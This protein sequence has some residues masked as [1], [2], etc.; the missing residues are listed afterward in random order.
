[1]IPTETVTFLNDMCLFAPAALID[2]RITWET[3]D[4]VSA[5]AT[6][7]TNNIR[8]SAILDFDEEGK[9]V[10][11]V[12][13]DR[14]SVDEMKAYPFSTPAG[15]YEN[16]NG[17]NLPM[18]GEGVWHYPDGEFVYGKFKVKSIEY[19]LTEFK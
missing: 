2:D 16:T 8:I 5:R 13:N 3:L 1:M 18:Y 7:T 19:N 9:L 12:S 14:Y 11:F 6:F 4:S 17:Y 15:N 10:N